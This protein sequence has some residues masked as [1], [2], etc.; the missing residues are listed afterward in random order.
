M[1]DHLLFVDIEASGLPRKWTVPYSQ[2]ENW[3]HAVQVAWLVYTRD[4]K[5]IKRQ[6]HYIRPD[7][8]TITDGAVAVHGLTPAFLQTH[9]KSRG[10]VLRR[11]QQDLAQ[12]TPMVIGHFM[13]FDFHVL[14]A[15]FYRENL[16]S[17]FAGLPTFCTMAASS[18]LMRLPRPKF[19]H[20]GELYS[21]LFQKPLEKQ[22]NALMDA[23]AAA[24]CFFE[25]WRRGEI[26]EEEVARQQEKRY[27]EP[28]GASR[29]SFS[30]KWLIL[31]AGVIL[32]FFLFYF[33]L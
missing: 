17:P 29:G 25:L 18:E 3:P 4:G 30:Y 32:L 19:L 11:L 7:G 21:F 2:D 15:D 22:H 9:G 6:D 1:Q 31:G 5:E 27:Q 23:T 16:P 33:W 10:E 28:K 20:L 14:S 12:Y 13:Q 26:T 8:F 24:D